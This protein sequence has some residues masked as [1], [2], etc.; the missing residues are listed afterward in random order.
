MPIF[1]EKN[2]KNARIKSL[3]DNKIES[4]E[5]HNCRRIEIDPE[6]DF[7]ESDQALLGGKKPSV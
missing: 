7:G 6:R 4:S 3:A 2:L 1:K 5:L